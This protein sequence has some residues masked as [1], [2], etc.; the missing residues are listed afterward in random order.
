MTDQARH[1]AAVLAEVLTGGPPIR[2]Q[3]AKVTAVNAG[4]P[5]TLDLL[6]ENTY[7]VSKVRYLLSYATPATNDAVYV[8]TYGPGRRVVIGEEA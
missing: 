5:K 3:K 8:V 6:I 2:I 4:P 7:A 1:S